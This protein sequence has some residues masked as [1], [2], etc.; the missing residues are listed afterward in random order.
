[1]KKTKELTGELEQLEKEKERLKEI[2]KKGIK[3]NCWKAKIY[4][5]II[6]KR[7]NG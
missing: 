7:T 5:C 1:M 2:L 3:R 4:N 6:W